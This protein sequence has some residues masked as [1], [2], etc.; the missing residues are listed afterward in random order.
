M[1]EPR[2]GPPS[3]PP[4]RPSR[5]A[6]PR[7][8]GSSRRAARRVLRSIAEATVTLFDAEAASIALHDP[9]TGQA[10]HPGGRRGGRARA[11][12]ASPSRS[13]EGIAGYVFT[14][15]QPLAVSD[16]AAD[17]RFDRSTGRGH[18]A[19]CRARSSRCR[20]STTAARIGVLEV[21]DRR[22][23]A[24]FGL[25]D[26]DLASVFARQAAVAIRAEPRG[27]R[28]GRAPAPGARAGSRADPDADGAA[29]RRGRGRRRRAAL[30]AEDGDRLWALADAVARARAAAPEQVAPRRRDPRRA[31]PPARPAA[32]RHGS[33]GDRRTSPPG[34]SRS[35][36]AAATRSPATGRGAGRT[37]A[38]AFGDGTG[39]RPAGGDRGLRRGGRRTRRSAGASSR[40]SRSSATA[41]GWRVVPAPPDG[42]R[43]PRDG[44]RGDHPR[45]SRRRRTSSRCACS[46]P[47]TAATAAAFATGL[48]W[49]IESS[50]ASVVNL[51]LSSR[52]DAFFGPLHELADEAYFRNV[53]LVS[54]ANNLVGRELPVAVRGGRVGRGPRRCRRAEAWFYNP[55]PP[56]EFGAY[57]LNVD[58]AWRGGTRMTVTG[59]SFA[60]PHIA[61]LAARIRAAHP[62]ITPFEAKAILAATADNATY[63]A[64]DA[65]RLRRCRLRSRS[66]T[67]RAL[68]RSLRPP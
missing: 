58:V 40:A 43:R 25:R 19:T 22:G 30:D 17:P 63:G 51:S 53:L 66:R 12:S 45:R 5:P 27:A 15:G 2:D 35:P 65:D 39:P 57:G 14:T 28:H 36:R 24:G 37:A 31:R 3:S 38:W 41:T 29:D 9:A 62:G 42:P 54:A 60:A 47:T 55:A 59:N 33:A 32:P 49:A 67:S 10:R 23:D 13:S 34:A 21:L 7:P 44:V 56:V 52:S 26:I 20:S 68:A 48:E 4:S 16:V 50:G 1:S 6:P 18:R 8:G 46:A 61:G 64:G 11:R